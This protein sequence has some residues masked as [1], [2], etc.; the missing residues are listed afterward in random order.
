ML[1]ADRPRRTSP[2]QPFAAP[3]GSD[4]WRRGRVVQARAC[5]ALYPGS[6]P[7]VATPAA[8]G[9]PYTVG[10]ASQPVARSE[11]RKLRSSLCWNRY[12]QWVQP[13][14]H[15]LTEVQAPHALSERSELDE[16]Q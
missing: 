14:G 9:R 1:A 13:S 6:I 5:K 11:E 4:T 8:R 7:G 15:L 2:G 3:V 12:Q 10:R 16:I